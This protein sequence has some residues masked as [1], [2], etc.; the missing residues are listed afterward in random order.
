ML[1]RPGA[2]VSAAPVDYERVLAKEGL[3]PIESDAPTGRRHATVSAGDIDAVSAW[4]DWARAVLD[5][6]RFDSD[7]QRRIWVL[8]ADGCSYSDIQRR[9]NLHRRSVTRA[10]AEVTL[11]VGPPPVANPWRRDG[12][13]E[14]GESAVAAARISSR[15][16]TARLLA[17]AIRCADQEQFRAL[18]A[19]DEELLRRLPQE[20]RIIM[21]ELKAK[22]GTGIVRYER[23]Q[24]LRAIEVP[25]N[26][27]QKIGK[28]L[29]LDVDGRPHN[30]GIEL[31]LDVKNAKTG[32][33]EK[34]LGVTVP[35]GLIV[36]ADREIA[37]E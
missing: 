36:Q 17:L 16:V 15:E 18:V 21:A 12:R 33:H 1:G 30:G 26:H 2:T 23:V 35:W 29:F 24:L 37:A 9:L 6:H 31:Q 11:M 5:S 27:G 8:Y 14:T 7:R 4:Q 13:G 19:Q 10:V 22:T 20:G 34:T 3:S 28:Q 25:G 32:E